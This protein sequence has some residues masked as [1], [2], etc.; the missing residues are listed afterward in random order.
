MRQQ[1]SAAPRL[2]HASVH[3]QLQGGDKRGAGSTR[4]PRA[5]AKEW[6]QADMPPS[7][8]ML[9]SQTLSFLVGRTTLS[10]HLAPVWSPALSIGFS[11]PQHGLPAWKSLRWRNHVPQVPKDACWRDLLFATVTAAGPGPCSC[12]C[13]SRPRLGSGPPEQRWVKVGAVSV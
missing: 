10:H 11:G 2:C 1:L 8:G 4:V 5:M 3:S 12:Q 6:G 9:L 7:A 13:G